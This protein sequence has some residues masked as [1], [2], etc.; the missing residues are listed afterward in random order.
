[1][2]PNGQQAPAKSL[3]LPIGV[4]RPADVNRL[5]REIM[6]VDDFLHQAEIRQS[7]Q[8]LSQLPRPSRLLNEFT[9]N[10][11]LNILKVE[12]RAA[13]VVFLKQVKL[14]A[15]IIHISFA[16]EPSAIFTSKLITWLRTH[17]HPLLLLQIGLQ[18]GLGA[19]C[20]VRTPNKYF[21]FSLR[22]HFDD[23]RELLMSKLEARP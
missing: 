11:H 6:D 23:Q 5:L 4:T 17:V 3:Q 10:N 12:D 8:S 20:V 22:K 18:P 2:E 14:S 21:D 15:P 9:D 13:G 16:T 1:M 7:G 19:G